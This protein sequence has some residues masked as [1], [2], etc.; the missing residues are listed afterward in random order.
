MSDLG[1]LSL[2][3]SL[4]LESLDA[5]EWTDSGGGG[6][7]DDKS[8]DAVAS[9]HRESISALKKVITSVK[10]T[11]PRVAE[12]IDGGLGVG[13]NQ[14]RHDITSLQTER[15]ELLG[16]LGDLEGIVMEH[17]SVAAS[18]N[19]YLSK[20]ILFDRDLASINS[21]TKSMFEA[22]FQSNIKL[23]SS[24]TSML[25][26]ITKV[27]RNCSTKL[28]LMEQ[29]VMALE[30]ARLRVDTSIMDSTKMHYP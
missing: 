27:S 24:T 19:N 12:K 13:L 21:K 18:I 3:R 9:K 25:R 7:M 5:D 30:G 15:D 22:I 17:G 6:I 28:Q 1:S 20:S 11:I 8:W 23:E 2:I 16:V 29:R 10:V 4:S 14:A 26:V